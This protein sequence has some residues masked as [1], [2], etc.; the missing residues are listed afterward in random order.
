MTSQATGNGVVGILWDYENVPLPKGYSGYGAVQRIRD[1]ALQYGT[2]NLFKAYMEVK[3]HATNVRAEL[4]ISGVSLTDTPHVGY[5]DVADQMLQVDMLVFAWDNPPPT[6]I[7]LIS[8]DRD[9]AYAAAILRNRNFRIVI[10]SPAQAVTCLR[11][12]ATHVY[13]W[14]T[15]V[16]GTSAIPQ[17]IH[18]SLLPKRPVPGS[19]Q[20]RVAVRDKATLAQQ[21]VDAWQSGTLAASSTTGNWRTAQRP[22]GANQQLQQAR[23]SSSSVALT[24]AARALINSRLVNKTQPST[25][26]TRV[27]EA[28]AQT[29]QLPSA[30]VEVS[31]S[32]LQPQT[33]RFPLDT[34]KID[35]LLS[36]LS[37]GGAKQAL[38][39]SA[40]QPETPEVQIV[41]QSSSLADAI[42]VEPSAPGPSVK[43]TAAHDNLSLAP[44]PAAARSRSASV[45]LLEEGKRDPIVI[46]IP[47][48]SK[49][50]A[51]FSAQASSSSMP[52]QAIV[53]EEVQEP[54][55]SPS[56]P[57]TPM[58]GIEA[59][60]DMGEADMDLDSSLPSSPTRLQHGKDSEQQKTDGSDRQLEAG[61]STAIIRDSAELARQKAVEV[62]NRLTAS[63]KAE[64][65]KDDVPGQQKTAQGMSMDLDIQ[66][67]KPEDAQAERE[68]AIA[69]EREAAA[70]A[71]EAA[72]AYVLKKAVAPSADSQAAGPS[73]QQARRPSLYERLTSPEGLRSNANNQ[74]YR[75]ERAPSPG[76]RRRR[77]SRS[78]SPSPM[79]VDGRQE[80]WRP[81][82]Q[83]TCV[84]NN[85]FGDDVIWM[86]GDETYWERVSRGTWDTRN[87]RSRSRSASPKRR[88]GSALLPRSPSRT[89]RAVGKRRA[90]VSVRERTPPRGRSRTPTARARSS[91]PMGSPVHRLPP[92]RSASTLQVP[93]GPPARSRSKSNTPF[94]PPQVAKKTEVKGRAPP[95]FVKATVTAMNGTASSS[96]SATPLAQ[97]P[98]ATQPAPDASKWKPLKEIVNVEGTS[99]PAKPVS[100]STWVSAMAA[101]QTI[102]PAAP[103]SLASKPGPIS[104]TATSTLQPKASAGPKTLATVKEELAPKMTTAAK[105][106]AGADAVKTSTTTA[107]LRVTTTTTATAPAAT[108]TTAAT[109][110]PGVRFK[111]LIQALQAFLAE[112]KF[113]PSRSVLAIRL[114]QFDKD[115]YGH[116]GLRNFKQYIE[117]AAQEGIVYEGIYQGVQW[118]ALEDEWTEVK[119]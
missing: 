36:T 32:S 2:I 20:Q 86:T 28:R 93:T 56:P 98:A 62:A 60:C 9:F 119:F 1:I 39:A 5:K 80:Y 95:R 33:Q 107:T 12:Q 19:S 101:G 21:N 97:A 16:L 90:S 88:G 23:P 83:G 79:L 85:D 57:P 111:P 74:H 102:L 65:R 3:G 106:K 115:A 81:P 30:P 118:V 49:N 69:R 17:R 82:L 51:Q 59:G 63:A 43:V 40:R 70:R 34:G 26:V 7:V 55:R 112:G 50:L 68:R 29:F 76:S 4:Q 109:S 6:T 15:E 46:S 53:E 103:S 54:P 71:R 89:S 99:L 114:M 94:V 35:L 37:N 47:K 91:S 22:A 18:P 92:A 41:P 75:P 108:G 8:G 66:H 58:E 48:N 100:T 96:S 24:I 61:S 44:Q 45:I 116:A 87:A 78:R 67:P 84:N 77:S 11:E 52:L 31:T 42:L 27:D 105:T 38:P 113:G 25:S 73:R 104:T 10:I 13:D 14:R 117:V 110:E 64:A 72:A